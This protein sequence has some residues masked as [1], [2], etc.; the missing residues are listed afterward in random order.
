[1]AAE[2]G[3]IRDRS[4]RVVT[5][6]Q[7][8]GGHLGSLAAVGCGVTALSPP[9][10]R[11]EPG[12]AD[13]KGA[14]PSDCVQGAVA[15]FGLFDMATIQEQAREVG[16]LLRDDAG[17]PEWRLLG[18]FATACPPTQLAA[19]SP[20]SYVDRSDPPMLLIVGAEDTVVPTKQTLKM[21][22]RLTSAGVK[23]DLI[24]LP[25]VNHSFIGKTSEAT[26]DANLKAL[27]AT[28]EFIDRTI[29]TRTTKSP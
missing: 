15:W 13:L 24:I 10:A 8:A 1:V 22:E 25:G 11:R 7:S 23:H 20:M 21:A 12:G 29:G 3:A 28:F 17:A 27:S 2:R 9:D 14:T 16:A 18:C 6:G 19:A 4:A 26:R 5:W